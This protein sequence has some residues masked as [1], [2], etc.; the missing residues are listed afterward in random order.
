[1]ERKTE[2][3]AG[4]DRWSVFEKARK[5]NRMHH[6]QAY[7]TLQ[8][9]LAETFSMPPRILDLGCG[10]AGDMA[11]V[12]RFQPV[13]SYTGVDNDPDVLS[14]A[15]MAFK[16]LSV[17]ARLILG[18]YEDALRSGPGSYDVI[19]LGLFLHHL[20]G[21]KKREFF[22]EAHR[23]IRSGGVL[24]VHDPVLKQGET[25]QEYIAR[26]ESACRAGWPELTAAEKD[27]MT[28]H[29]SLHGRQESLS[30]LESMALAGGFGCMEV[31]WNDPC[32]FYAVMAFWN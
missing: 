16:E 26:I 15:E 30:A 21:A 20:P 19:W 23:L 28:R 4:F 7:Q 29:W 14:R 12:L 5:A 11:G 1:M 8:H 17:P 25:R 22:Q 9:T 18:G 2:V 10:D 32:Q 27:M 31:L 3:N 6:A 13:Q 24:L